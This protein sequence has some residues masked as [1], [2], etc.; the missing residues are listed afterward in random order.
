MIPDRVK[1]TI[2]VALGSAVE[3]AMRRTGRRRGLAVMYHRVG[4]PA[5]DPLH[6]LV[7]A[8]S[9]RLFESQLRYLR[10]R[11]RVVPASELLEATRARRRGE[12]FPVAVT[13][14]DD[15]RSHAEVAMP[16]LRDLGLVGT[17][18]VSGASLDG[19]HTFWW[20]HLQRAFDRRL[21]LAAVLPAT[22][23]AIADPPAREEIR[24]IAEVLI[25]DTSAQER[26]E[27]ADALG[28]LVGPD[29]A[30]GGIS[31]D[32]LRAIAASGQ[33]IGFHTRRHDYLPTLDDGS[34][35]RAMIEGR[36]EVESVLGQLLTMLAYPYGGWDRRVAEAARA[37]GYS[38][39]F[40]TDQTVVHP[41]SDELAIGR[42]EASFESIGHFA[43]QLARTLII[44]PEA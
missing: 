10:D 20:E 41:G 39:A 17:F 42:I 33:Q 38:L 21:P 7:P 18:F 5:G 8:L 11:Y 44:R 28:A 12:R 9:A 3:Q 26:A 1:P 2:G 23:A 6:E 16:I 29:A 35:R 37:A 30:E 22:V 34:L 32:D 36:T 40:T 25:R 43:L 14:D 13:F 27:I 15:L 31:A 19:P 24:S 4:D